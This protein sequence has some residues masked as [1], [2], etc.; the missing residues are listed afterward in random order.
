VFEFAQA[1]VERHGDAVRL[2]LERLARLG[3]RFSMDQVTNLD[4]D[5]ADL[6]RRHI[7]FIKVEAARLVHEASRKD[8]R[9]DV[10]AIKKALDAKAIDIIADKIESEQVLVELLDLPIDFGQG[11]LFGEP[12]LSRES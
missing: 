4:L 2:D 9:L 1:H 7:R 10:A 8:L 11:Y 3:F 5:V 6:G 12:R